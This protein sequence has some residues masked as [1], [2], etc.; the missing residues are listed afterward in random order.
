MR[1]FKLLLKAG[2][3]FGFVLCFLSAEAQSLK[4][5]SRSE[6]QLREAGDRDQ[7][8]TNQ[9]GNTANTAD[10]AVHNSSSSVLQSLQNGINYLIEN[11]DVVDGQK[12]I[13][14]VI[15]DYQLPI[16]GFES[17]GE[18]HSASIQHFVN[19]FVPRDQMDAALLEIFKKLRAEIE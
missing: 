4:I 8:N 9:S 18:V 2:F 15:D 17:L 19:S 11:S 16:Q 3:L 7:S 13:Q 10:E 14:I 5:D 1:P 12:L 6:G